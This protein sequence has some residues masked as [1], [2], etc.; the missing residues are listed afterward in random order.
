MKVDLGLGNIVLD[1]DPAPPPWG[2]APNFRPMSVV[3]KQLDGSRCHLIRRYASAQATFC[4]M[5]IRLPQKGHSRPQFSAHVY[6]GQ[7]V[8]HLSYC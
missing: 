4:Y 6:C 5:W 3:A 8:T 7:M 1:A 2:T